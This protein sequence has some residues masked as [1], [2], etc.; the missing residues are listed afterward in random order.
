MSG[1][2]SLTNNFGETTEN[3]INLQGGDGA[4]LITA[5]GPAIYSGAGAPAFEAPAGS[6]YLRNDG[7]NA[8]EVIYVNFAGNTTWTAK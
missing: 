8:N 7:A 6:L 2:I 5:A 1:K 3:Y 4:D